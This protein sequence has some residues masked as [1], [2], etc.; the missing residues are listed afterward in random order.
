MRSTCVM[1]MRRQQYR[2]QPSWSSAS[3]WSVGVS[4]RGP[5]LCVRKALVLAPTRH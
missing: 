5:V 3:L 4:L 2:L 1:T